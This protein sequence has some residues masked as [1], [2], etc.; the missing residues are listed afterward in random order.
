MA[1]TSIKQQLQ[2]I[3]KNEYKT[4]YVL[5]KYCPQYFQGKELNSIDDLK[6][7]WKMFPKSTD[8]QMALNWELEEDVSKGIKFLLDKLHQKKMVDVYLTFYEKAKEG[9]VASAKF[10]MDFSKEFFKD[11]ISELE[12]LL[13]GIEV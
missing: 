1:S 8:E 10:L 12:S 4:I 11:S 7:N 6:A 9:D 5:W 3:I 13:N 2:D